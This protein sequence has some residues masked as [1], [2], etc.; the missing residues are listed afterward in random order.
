MSL[1]PKILA[2][3]AGGVLTAT[4]V[5]DAHTYG[6]MKGNVY[7]QTG[8]AEA[9]TKNMLNMNMLEQPDVLGNGA[10]KLWFRNDMS[11]NARQPF[12]FI[13]GYVKGF[14]TMVVNNIVPIA[15]GV[16]TMIA[17]KKLNIAKTAAEVTAKTTLK[18]AKQ[19]LK[20]GTGTQAAVDTAKRAL[21]AAAPSSVKFA[22]A[23]LA[24]LGIACV[25]WL[26]G[27]VITAIT[28]NHYQNALENKY[29]YK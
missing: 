28:G 13:G 20:V 1:V 19:A 8:D 16:G 25:A 10:K 6:A 21:K 12:N 11:W 14:G 9:L 29:S 5:Y 22:R 23:G 15:L 18:T 24:G 26:A 4:K 7:A 17:A 27:T 2:A 3:A